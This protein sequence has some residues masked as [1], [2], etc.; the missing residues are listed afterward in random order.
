M[1]IGGT[2]DSEHSSLV[3]HFLPSTSKL[4]LSS[5]NTEREQGESP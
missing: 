5:P 3:K 1:E 2:L 4:I